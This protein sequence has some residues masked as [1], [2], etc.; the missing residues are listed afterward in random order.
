MKI[1]TS[2]TQSRFTADN[3][4]GQVSLKFYSIYPNKTIYLPKPSLIY[5]V[6]QRQSSMQSL[7][8][9]R[10]ISS[11]LLTHPSSCNPAAVASIPRKSCNSPQATTWLLCWSKVKLL[12]EGN[13]STSKEWMRERSISSSHLW[14]SI[15]HRWQIKASPFILSIN[16]I[17]VHQKKPTN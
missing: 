15:L 8:I 7:L 12:V 13:F 4:T 9:A 17:V 16:G 10:A 5:P 6:K 1:K 2:F 14:Q 3:Q 11:L